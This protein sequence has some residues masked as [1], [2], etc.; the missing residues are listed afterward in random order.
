MDAR[1]SVAAHLAAVFID[2][3][4]VFS[5]PPFARKNNFADYTDEVDRFFAGMPEMLAR[6]GFRV[7]N[8][9]SVYRSVIEKRSYQHVLRR[10]AMSDEQKRSLHD[11]FGS[12]GH[13][14]EC[15]V[16]VAD[17]YMIKEVMDRATRGNL[18]G[19]VVLVTADTDFRPLAI[20]LANIGRFVVIVG[21]RQNL[22]SKPPW[23]TVAHAVIP[24]EEI[25][26]QATPA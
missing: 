12:R 3:E 23:H 1:T 10:P 15:R 9:W 17:A 18:P 5:T 4:N 25:T 13:V 22:R 19:C 2:I 11:M 26:A 7:G 6:Y 24:L 14:A 20:R 16:G 8:Y 21:R